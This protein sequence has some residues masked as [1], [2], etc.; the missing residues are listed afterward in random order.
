MI[1]TSA[2][3]GTWRCSRTERDPVDQGLAGPAVEI[4]DLSKRYSDGTW[5]NLNMSL[6]VER[7][8]LL[9]VLGPNGAGK[10][11]LIRQITTELLPTSGTVHV[12][13]RDAVSDPHAVKALLGVVP[14]EASLYTDLSVWHHFRLFAKMRGFSRRSAR[15]RADELVEALRLQEHR[16]RP[17]Q[18]LS[19]GLRRRMLVGIA[20]LARPPLLVL[21]E[22]T[23][24]LD[25]Q[26]RRDLWS[27]VR[28]YKGQGTTVILTTHYMEEAEA[29]SDRVG[30]IHDGSVVALDTIDNLRAAHDLQFRATFVREGS[31]ESETVHGADDRELVEQI[32]AQGIQQYTI[33]KANLEDVYLALT[34]EREVLDETS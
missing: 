14:Q 26:S 33:S 19:G 27:L 32:R 2:M 20:T 11:T 23:T 16:D 10:T 21:D 8:E 31:V 6:T 7:G 25:P 5:A 30:I 9:A 17:T 1:V 4:S 12:F 22:P 3:W 24:G 28:R 13:G 18:T 34:G 29:L 15:D